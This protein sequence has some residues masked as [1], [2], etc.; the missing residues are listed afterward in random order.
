MKKNLAN[1]RLLLLGGSLWKKAIQD[2]AQEQGI[3]L[4]ATGNNHNAGIFEIADECYDVD[5][6]NTEAMKQLIREKRIDGVYMGGSESVISTACGYLQELGLP[7]YCTREQWEYL[8]NKEH[9]K[10]LCIEYGLP[11]VPKYDYELENPKRNIPDSAFPVITK[12]TDGCGSSGFSVCRNSEELRKGYAIA[13]QASPT[14]SVIVEKFVKNDGVVVFYTFSNGKMYFS[15]LEDKY[16][17]KYQKQGSYVGGLFVFE[18]KLTQEFRLHFDE[19]IAEMFQSIGIREGS[20]WIEVFHDGENY[21]FISEHTSL[22]RSTLPR[23]KYYCI[24]PVHINAGTISS[25]SGLDKIAQLENIVYLATTKYLHDRIESSGSF[26]QVFALVHFVC[27]TT[28]ECIQTIDR[29]HQMLVVFDEHGNNMVNRM[30]DV[31]KII[32]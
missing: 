32:F 20:V 10:R 30:L 27:N 26:S 5:S 7:C 2:F 23:K 15:G 17:V 18:S 29:I 28:E 19:K 6:T 8:Q 16:P 22:I 25:I 4:I 14:G 13:R 9:F 31:G 3:I 1:K 11:V 12:P 21:Y 24:Y